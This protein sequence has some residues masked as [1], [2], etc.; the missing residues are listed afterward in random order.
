M[1]AKCLKSMYEFA[2]G[3]N[4][5]MFGACTKTNVNGGRRCGSR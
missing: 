2:S 1:E 5:S 3:A 4:S